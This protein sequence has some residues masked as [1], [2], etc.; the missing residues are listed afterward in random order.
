MKDS[1]IDVYLSREAP[2]YEESELYDIYDSIPN[3]NLRRILSSLH[4][5]LNHWFTVING[6]LR[7]SYDEEGNKVYSGGYFHAQ[8]SRDLLAVLDDLDKLKRKLLSTQYEF[9]LINASYDNAIRRC[10]RFLLNRNGSTI[11]EDFK[12]I[13]IED[14][15]PIFQIK[16]SISIQTEAQT[17][18]AALD[19]V[20]EGSYA[21]V[22][23]YEEPTYKIKIALK[24]AKLDLDGKELE[25][26]RQEF[27]VL[28]SLNSP[29]IVQ[30]YAYNEQKKIGRAHV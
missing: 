28:K 26:F 25:R 12:P 24:R 9:V 29:Y 19:S 15:E 5:Q 13:E 3:A 23:V 16:N 4:S 14:V 11:P 27:T 20:G 6:D 21:R 2:K 30:V 7:T 17:V 22:F 8:D 1:Y 10:K 18:Y